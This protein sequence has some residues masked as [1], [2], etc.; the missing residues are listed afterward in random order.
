M[1]FYPELPKYSSPELSFSISL[2][3][4]RPTFPHLILALAAGSSSSLCSF[5][6][7]R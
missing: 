6:S 1:N 2:L 4:P 3:A 7:V 5:F